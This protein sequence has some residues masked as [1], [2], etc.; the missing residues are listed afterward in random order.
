RGPD[1]AHRQPFRA[2]DR[3]RFALVADRGAV[4]AGSAGDAAGQE[5]F[6]AHVRRR[7]PCPRFPVPVLGE[8]F[9]T[10]F[11]VLVDPCGGAVRGAHAG[12]A[13]EGVRY[14]ARRRRDRLGR[15]GA[16]GPPLDQGR[17]DPRFTGR[18]A[19]GGAGFGDAGHADQLRAFGPGR[20][21]DRFQGPF[22]PVP[23]RRKRTT[24]TAARRVTDRRARR[25]RNA[26]H[27]VQRD[28]FGTYQRG[29]GFDPPSAAVPVLG[30]R[31]HFARGG[32]EVADRGAGKPRH[33]RGS[34]Q[35]AVQGAGR[36]R[37]RDDF[38]FGP[39]PALPQRE[40]DPRGSP[41]FADGDAIHR[42]RAGDPVQGRPFRT[43][44]I[45]GRLERPF[46]PVPA[47][48][49]RRTGHPTVGRAF[50]D[51]GAARGRRAT[52]TPQPAVQH[53]GRIGSAGQ[54]PSRRRR[55]PD[56]EPGVPL[57]RHVTLAFGVERQP[58]RVFE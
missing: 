30:H 36:F 43:G 10:A 14:R 40:V 38:P 55:A 35:G 3:Q 56:A 44:G 48:D 54:L 28:L 6:A 41:V 39:V 11:D 50:A 33:A 24:R 49:Q 25:L 7:L 34:V 37:G 23:A 42:P 31:Q 27:V 13:I 15:P 8:R 58:G 20:Q 45:G 22:G 19:D 1:F 29:Q 18:D 17:F 32:F 57:I 9:V 46:A 47:V 52:H 5:P 21:A 16:A 51:R 12:N 26:G 2:D 53:F 4:A